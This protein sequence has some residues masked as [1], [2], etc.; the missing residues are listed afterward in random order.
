[1]N[2]HYKHG[3][4]GLTNCTAGCYT[5]ILMG[6][7]V[8]NS[9]LALMDLSK[10]LNSAQTLMSEG[11]IKF[12]LNQIFSIWPECEN[13]K[14]CIYACNCTVSLKGIKVTYRLL[15]KLQFLHVDNHEKEII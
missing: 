8:K 13:R 4:H 6:K 10:K 9:N 3:N 2:K 15:Y 7:F 11:S 14:A 12:L 1:M 5:D